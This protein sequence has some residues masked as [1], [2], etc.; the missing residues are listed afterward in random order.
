VQVKPVQAERADSFSNGDFESGNL[1]Q[2]DSTRL[3]GQRSSAVQSDNVRGGQYAARLTLFPDDTLIFGGY[4]AELADNFYAKPESQM[5]YFFSVYLP[6][7]TQLHP[8]QGCV[9]AQFH[10]QRNYKQFS[11]ATPHSPPLAF[12][13]RGDNSIKI[14]IERS[15]DQINQNVER[16]QIARIKNFQ[17]GQ[18]H[19]FVVN[20][21]WSSVNGLVEIFHKSQSDSEF[22]KV[23][24]YQGVLGYF[25]S[26][27]TYFKVG[28]YC[29]SRAPLKPL[30]VFVDNYFRKPL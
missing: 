14:T 28:P 5:Q 20:V 15:L 7:D 27:G 24:D 19:D 3:T 26:K 17:L 2:W 9:I 6:S 1:N 10:D 13:Y 21:R 8:D 25:G 22:Q 30:T 11:L 29:N 18:W 12:R 16:F 23:S 4:R